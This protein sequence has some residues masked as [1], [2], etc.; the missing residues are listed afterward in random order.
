MTRSPL[1]VPCPACNVS[2]GCYCDGAEPYLERVAKA[3]EVDAEAARARAIQVD[4]VE[5]CKAWLR[6]RADGCVGAGDCLT[7]S[8]AADEMGLEVLP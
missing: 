4:T 5:R 1:D 8:R 3:G 6:A 7:L 2:A